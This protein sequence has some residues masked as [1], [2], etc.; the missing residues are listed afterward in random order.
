MHLSR[1]HTAAVPLF[2]GVNK[3]HSQEANAEYKSVII[4][5]NMCFE[6]GFY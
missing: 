1:P 5:I 4:I 6:I 3:S 2:R